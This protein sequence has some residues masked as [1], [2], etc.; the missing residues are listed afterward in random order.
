MALS[1]GSH[2]G[3]YEIHA[4]I[5]AGGMGEVY[6][7]RDTRLGRDVA[8]KILPAE[9]V[10]HPDRVRRFELEAR[11][12]AALNHP[13]I[14]TLYDIGTHEGSPH[15]VMELLEGESLG[16]MLTEGPIPVRQAIDIAT[17]VAEGLAAAHEKNIVHR[18]LKPGNVFVTKDGR[19]KILDFGLARL[20][21]GEGDST[22]DSLAPTADPGT[23]PGTVLGTV[24]YMSPE[25]VKGRPADARSDIFSL[26]V[27]L[28][29]M[30]TGER[31][32]KGDSEAEVMTAILKEDP[33]PL[34][35]LDLSVPPML[36]RTVVHCLEKSPER[37]FQSAQDIVFALESVTSSSGVQV[38]LPPLPEQGRRRL[39]KRA[40]IGLALGCTLAAL[41]GV[42]G[43]WGK[44]KY[45]KPAPMYKRVTYR[46]G[47]VNSARFAPDRQSVV[48]SASWAGGEKSALY[49]QRLASPDARALGVSG[50]VVGVTEADLLYLHGLPDELLTLSQI[51]LEGGTPRDLLSGLYAADCSRK[52]MKLAIVRS[53][54]TLAQKNRLLEYPVGNALVRARGIQ[55]IQAPRI[56]PDGTLVAYVWRESAQ[57]SV[58]DVCVVDS[59]GRIRTL[60]K[61][62]INPQSLAWSPDGDEVWVMGSQASSK[63]EIHAVNL[64]GRERL[65]TRLPGSVKLRDIAPDGR[66]LITLGS[67][68][69]ELRGLM[70]GDASEQDYSWLVGSIMPCLSPDGTQVVFQECGEAGGAGG[71]AYHWKVGD[72]SPKRIAAGCPVDVSPDWTKVLVKAGDA[73]NPHLDTVPIGAGEKV[74]LPRGQ[75]KRL[76]WARWHPDGKRIVIMGGDDRFMRALYVQD[77]S[78]GSPRYLAEGGWIATFA[79]DGSSVLAMPKEGWSKRT[80]FLSFP[81]N[82][83]PPTRIPYLSNGDWPVEF[84]RDGR[85]LF[86][87]KDDLQAIENCTQKVERLDLKTHRRESWLKLTPPDRVGA[88]LDTGTS[89]V[90]LTPD[91][92]YYLYGFKRKLQD[93][94]LVEGLK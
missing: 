77:L 92:R 10:D 44:H 65:V 67:E 58:G 15:L 16:E 1:S 90:W 80:P 32:F 54:A 82:G 61:G 71:S 14:L 48:Y 57:G 69:Y 49:V 5:G 25:Q 17:Q 11:A 40:L 37:R 84:S 8:I 41:L 56:S 26:G 86:V 89:L 63:P 83:D 28:R 45:A 34:S 74:S 39:L 18:D 24:S 38:A 42:G 81:L 30:L 43:L 12:V 4:P 93:L 50:S 66:L 62:W 76:G 19:A 36:E 70:A 6:R 29:E 3:P 7:A 60:V 55:V 85:F 23:K 52:G 87:I 33:P 53:D 35:A 79:P 47:A 88:E 46:R 64:S 73:A 27:I 9:F 72:P 68:R 20:V 51:P 91:G 22:P 21:R 75:L 2:L 31:T 13:N 94:Y 59:T 78:G